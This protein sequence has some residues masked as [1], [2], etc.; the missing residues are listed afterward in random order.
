[1]ADEAKPENPYAGIDWEEV[2]AQA[3]EVA[4]EFLSKDNAEE[5]VAIGFER[6]LGGQAP[7]KKGEGETLPRHVVGVGFNRWRTERRNNKRR[8]DP[9]V[10]SKLKMD[11]DSDH[12]TPEEEAAEREEK[13]R[14][15]E[16]LLEASRDDADALAI[17]DAEAHDVR[18]R[19]AQQ[20]HCK[21]TGDAW[22][23]A[24]NRIGARIKRILAE[25]NE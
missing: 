9:E 10:V 5:V 18:G 3:L 24:R 25:E 2:Y 13:T 6:V 17:L 1:M 14:R 22:N 4:L 11:I 16:A 23:N 15:Y 8:Q 19:K 7:W 21:L 12:P 20:E